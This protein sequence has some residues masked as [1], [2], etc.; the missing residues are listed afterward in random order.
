MKIAV[1]GYSGSGKSTLTAQLGELYGVP[2]LHLDT[3]HFLP[4]W[5]ERGLEEKRKI[6][7]DFLN[8]NAGWIIDGNYLRLFYDERM[9]QADMI[10]ILLFGRFACLWRVIK[11][12]RRYKNKT[13]PD[14]SEGCDEKLNGEFIRWVL[15]DGRTKSKKAVFLALREKYPD[16]TVILKNQRQLDDFI[17]RSEK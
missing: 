14:M 5:E 12:Y 17:R 13:R 6:V 4:N 1:L 3:V 9:E 7:S 16:K 15:H 10:I 8:A 11:R 2:V